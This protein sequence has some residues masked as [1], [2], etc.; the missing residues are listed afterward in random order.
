MRA[1]LL[2]LLCLVVGDAFA[3]DYAWEPAKADDAAALNRSMHA[4][5]E[6]I[7]RDYREPDRDRYLSTVFR[8]Q[9]AAGHYDAALES[10]RELRALR[11]DGAATLFL[12]YELYAWALKAHPHFPAA[13]RSVFNARFAALDDLSAARIEPSFGGNLPMA[14]ASLDAALEKHRDARSL[15][16]ADALE[17][18]R[19]YQFH[20]T[21]AAILPE[22][23]ALL[24]ADEARRYTIERDVLVGTPDGARISTLVVRAKSVQGRQPT[25]MGFTVYAND[26]WALADAKTVASHGYHA[27]VA[28]SRGKG[29][30][31]DAIAPFEHDGDD[32][33]AVIDWIAAQDWSDGRVGMY[34]GSYNTFAQWSAAK[35]HPKALK[36]LMTSASAAPGIDTPM[37][38]NVFLNF[39][40]P[41]PFYVGNNKALDDDTY[42]DR[43]RWEKLDRDWYRSGRAY[44]DMDQVDGTPNPIFRRWLT[45]PAYDAYWQAMI[46]Y[47]EEF[48]AIDIPVLSTTGY[49]DGARVGALYYFQEH[50]Q[51]NPKADHTLVIGPWGHLAMQAGVARHVDGYD[52]DPVAQ[53]DLQALRYDW[54]DHVF[55][56]KPKPAL[57]RDRVNYQVM[58]ADAWRHAPS[59]D[60]MSNARLRFRLQADGQGPHRLAEAK[61]ANVSSLA[62]QVDMRDR[63]DA[64]LPI[65]TQAIVDAPDLRNGLLF[66]SAPVTEPTEIAGLFS[67]ELDFVVNKRDLDLTVTLYEKMT[68]GC[69]FQLAHHL[70]RASHAESRSERRLLTPGKRTRLAFTSERL[71]SRKL[72]PGS[73]LAIVLAVNRQPDMQINYGSGKDVAAETIDDAGEPLRVEWLSDSYIDIPIWR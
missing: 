19:L 5:A 34:G 14:K 57:L 4:L 73:R 11:G 65:P 58:G 31:P 69:Y 10:I 52:V 46:P 3:Q 49:F 45:H 9:L 42:G 62:Q 71:V 38:G 23:P 2:L 7:E 12:Q 33:A 22:M 28:Y 1:A 20:R 6:R 30:S 63:S 48:A 26:D 8:S 21:F 72:S 56:G 70:G 64:D 37:Q 50:T 39:M 32:A 61:P 51:R 15:A 60:A 68:D 54:F 29:A 18:I 41:W 44:R 17:L 40:Y 55:R 24:A 25:L 67:G 27:V 66:L 53:I 36:A 16:Q 59:I 43:A 35:R 13:F 47:R